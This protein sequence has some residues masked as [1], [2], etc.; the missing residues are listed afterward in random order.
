[1]GEHRDSVK[2]GKQLDAKSIQRAFRDCGQGHVF[3]HWESLDPAGQE[4]MLGQAS[5]IASALPGLLTDRTTA[6]NS[7]QAA[8]PGALTPAPAI[9]LPEHG[10]DATAFREAHEHGVRLLS[11]GRVACLVVAG[12]QGSR[13]GFEGPKG[14]YPVGPVSERSLFAIQAQKIRALARRVGR[15]VPWLIMTSPATHTATTN[16]FEQESHFGLDEDDVVIFSQGTVPAWTFD[17]KKILCI[18][19][20][21]IVIKLKKESKY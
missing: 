4:R 11:E 18:I 6:L 7:L 9:A 5:R 19:S 3:D 2:T 17:G 16:L 20:K 12:G 21:L 8:P 1:M 15:P 13:L 14:A 10:G